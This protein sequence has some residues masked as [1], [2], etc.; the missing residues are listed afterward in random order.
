MQKLLVAVSLLWCAYAQ[1]QSSCEKLAQ[2]ALPQAKITSA[3]TIAAGALPIPTNIPPWI[4]GA[5]SLFKSLPAF[6]RVS[7]TSQPS[8]D[9]D[10][11]IEIWMPISGWNG[12]FQGQGNGGFAGYIDYPA[13]AHAVALGYATA[14]TDTGHSSR[15]S[16]PDAGW[17]LGHPEKIVD[18]GYRGIHEMTDIGKKLAAAFYGH[19]PQHSYFGSCSNGGR[20]ALME[21]QRFPEDYDGILAGAP[22]NYW[23]HLLSDGLWNAQATTNDPASFIPPAK[24]TTIAAA[25]NAACDAQ[26]GVK[27][28][29][30][31]DPRECHFDPAMLACKAGDSDQCLTQPQATALKKIYEGAHDASG[32]I[33]PGFLPGAEGGQQGWVGWITGATPGQAALVFFTKGFFGDMVYENANWNYKTANLTDAVKLADA[34][35]AKN[36]NATDPNLEQFRARGGKLL[37]YHG[38]NDPAIPAPNTVNYYDDVTKHMGKA[39]TESFVRLYMVPGMQHCGGGPGTTSFGG[40]LAEPAKDAQHNVRL[41]LENWVEKGDAPAEIIASHY[42]GTGREATMTRPLCP[43]PEQ[44][45][46]KGSGDSNKAENFACAAPSR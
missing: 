43:Y 24:I 6:C 30:L 37:L 36:L 27:D 23:T 13:M 15:G 17:A 35:E 5:A 21:A 14:S 9:S 45:K 4:E 29:I 26:D 41:A 8:A 16:L 22:A 11:K 3:Q 19:P 33:F 42:A 38:W 39:A 10:I 44:A 12:K 25:V 40:D 31:N 46:Y 32:Q 1:A 34:K 7:V 20:Q 2:T 18:Y 28:G